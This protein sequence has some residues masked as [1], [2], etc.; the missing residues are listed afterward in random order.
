MQALVI[1]LVFL[2]AGC[3]SLLVREDDPGAVVVSKVLWRTVLGIST[4]GLSELNLANHRDEYD[5]Q[6]K[7]EE[8]NEHLTYQVNNGQLTQ[9][10]AEQLYQQYAA[11]LMQDAREQAQRRVEPF[12]AFAT[13]LGA[14]LGIAAGSAPHLKQGSYPRSS[15]RWRHGDS[16][17]RVSQPRL[18][19]KS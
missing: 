16:Y 18:F 13:G 15:Y 10:E 2:L 6:Q 19:P 8:Y 1:T 9:S 7:L 11:T 14:G 3:S 5:V 4:L 17:P 12:N